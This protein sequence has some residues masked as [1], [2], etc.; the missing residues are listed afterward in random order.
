MTADSSTSTESSTSAQSPLD[1]AFEH[2][3]IAE[4]P[5]ILV[6]AAFLGGLVPSP[7]A[8]APAGREEASSSLSIASARRGR[9]SRAQGET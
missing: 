3:A 4:H 8:T 7:A 6:G 1:A 5:E 2:D 9:G